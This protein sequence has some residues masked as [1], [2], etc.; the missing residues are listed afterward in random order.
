MPVGVN[1]VP[2]RPVSEATQPDQIRDLLARLNRDAAKVAAKDPDLSRAIGQLAEVSARPDKADNPTFRTQTA[3]A[4]QDFEKLAGPISTV[5]PA[6]REEMTRLAATAPGLQNDRLQ[7]LVRQT[8]TLGDRRVIADIRELAL[9]TAGQGGDQNRQEV[10]EKVE[11][12][13]NRA[14]LAVTSGA[15]I[16]GPPREAVTTPVSSAEPGPR[17]VNADSSGTQAQRS[18]GQ[19][20]TRQSRTPGW[21]EQQAQTPSPQQP[22]QSTQPYQSATRGPGALSLVLGALANRWAANASEG[23]SERPPSPIADRSARHEQQ[24]QGQRD[25]AA[26]ATAEKS[27]AAALGAIRDFANGPASN[28]LTKIQDAVRNDPGGIAAVLSE[29][30]EGG[31]F[32]GLRT[33]LNADLATEKGAAAAYDRM[34]GALA[35]Y[36]GDR[37]AV[38]AI[39]ARTNTAATLTAKFEKVDAEIGNAA[40]M[41]PSRSDGKS[42]MDDLGDKLRQVLDRAMEAVKSVFTPSAERAARASASPSPSP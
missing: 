26:V 23:V 27:Q 15:T 38:E 39:G 7:D 4:L 10:R 34:T 16:G 13:E 5:P 42:V 3:Y 30:R 12:L 32:A 33:Q 2:E 17:N 8:P 19:D 21:E 14:R 36:G 1:S 24:F 28:I 31:R 35:Q 22:V 6:L 37:A 41:L 9:N 18:P 29:M 11:A 20:G 40:S 25:D